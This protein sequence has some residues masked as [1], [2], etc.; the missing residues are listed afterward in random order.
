MFIKTYECTDCL[1]EK[2]EVYPCRD[3]DELIFTDCA[4]PMTSTQCVDFH[5]CDSCYNG[6][7]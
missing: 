2:H 4:V 3:C 1:Q 7:E 5:I 6:L